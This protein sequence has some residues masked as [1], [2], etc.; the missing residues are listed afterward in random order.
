VISSLKMAFGA[1]ILKNNDR[2]SRAIISEISWGSAKSDTVVKREQSG[3]FDVKIY[4][5]W[6]KT[7]VADFGF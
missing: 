2:K 6:D 5:S 7:K 4:K 1:C 3:S